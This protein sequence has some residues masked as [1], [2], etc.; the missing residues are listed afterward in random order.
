M[1]SLYNFDD[2]V[3]AENKHQAVN[4]LKNKYKHLNNLEIKKCISDEYIDSINDKL[5][6]V[7]NNEIYYA[8]DLGN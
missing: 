3:V 4:F 8:T 7:K 5:K 1:L 6:V 2:K